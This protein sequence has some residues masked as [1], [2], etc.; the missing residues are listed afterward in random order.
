MTMQK[1]EWRSIL[2]ATLLLKTGLKIRYGHIDEVSG[3]GLR[4]PVRGC[5]WG[6]RWKG[7]YNG[8]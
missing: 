2:V 8:M 1:G 5:C 7:T 3:G 6:L 4:R